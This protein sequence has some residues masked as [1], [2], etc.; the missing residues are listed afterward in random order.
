[1]TNALALARVRPN[2]QWQYSWKTGFSE[3]TAFRLA[4]LP[5]MRLCG[6]FK[7]NFPD[8]RLYGNLAEA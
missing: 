7:V 1:M 2:A 4:K 6:R 5:I 3:T 8:S